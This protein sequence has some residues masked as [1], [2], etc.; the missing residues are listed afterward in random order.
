MGF[1][2]NGV[3]AGGM[4]ADELVTFQV[5]E[6][7]GRRQRILCPAQKEYVSGLANMGRGEAVGSKERKPVDFTGGLRVECGECFWT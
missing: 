1:L 7:C 2:E 4:G 6:I 3:A 5:D